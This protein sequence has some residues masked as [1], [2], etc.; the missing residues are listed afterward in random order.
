MA[1]ARISP[2]IGAGMLF[3]GGMTLAMAVSFQRTHLAALDHQVTTAI[4]VGV[5]VFEL[6]GAPVAGRV[7]SR[8]RRP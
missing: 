1:R 4:V 3:Q 6:I 7:L 2:L 5:I 8:G